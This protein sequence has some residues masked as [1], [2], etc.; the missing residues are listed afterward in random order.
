MGVRH[1]ARK[2]CEAIMCDRY[3]SAYG[4]ICDNCFDELVC[5]GARASASAFLT[6]EPDTSVRDG[7]SWTAWSSVFRE[8]VEHDVPMWGADADEYTARMWG[9]DADEPDVRI[10]ESFEEYLLMT[11][12]EK[13]I[14]WDRVAANAEN[15][16]LTREWQ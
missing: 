7:A 15:Q 12:A 3:S 13:L 16:A 9:A 11:E 4:Y 2:G 10:P 5:L 8:Y 6:S 1:C 14:L